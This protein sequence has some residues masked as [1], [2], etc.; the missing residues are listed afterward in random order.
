MDCFEKLALLAELGN[1]QCQLFHGLGA[2]KP[3][4]V[5]YIVVPIGYNKDKVRDI[6]A[7]QG[8][9]LDCGESRWG[10]RCLA[11]NKYRHKILWLKGCPECSGKFGGLYFNDP[12]S[13]HSGFMS[14]FQIGG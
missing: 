1:E 12:I 9:C 5:N 6:S 3:P 14:N 7:L 4:A 2:E 11:R 8:Y 13:D 10:L